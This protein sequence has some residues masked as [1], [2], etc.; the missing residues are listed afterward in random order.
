M[1]QQK[2]KVMSDNTISVKPLSEFHTFNLVTLLLLPLILDISAIVTKNVPFAMGLLI[3]K[4]F[5]IGAFIIFRLFICNVKLTVNSECLTKT[6]GRKVIFKVDVK[7]IVAIYI[8]QKSKFYIFKCWL[9]ILIGFLVADEEP[10]LANK[11]HG[12]Y[13]SIVHKD[14]FVCFKEERPLPSLKPITMKYFYE[15]QES[16]SVRECMKICKVMGIEPQ[17]IT[18]KKRK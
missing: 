15:H 13:I 5:I 9:Y 14:S 18:K 17:I 6:K 11:Q 4:L 7:E 10:I 8:K 12:T 1:R 3:Y 16:L 2:E